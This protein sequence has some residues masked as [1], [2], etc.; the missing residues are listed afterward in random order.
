MRCVINIY[1]IVYKHNKKKIPG[2]WAHSF[3]HQAF[4]SPLMLCQLIMT[5][6][7]NSRKYLISSGVDVFIWD[8]IF[9]EDCPEV[10]SELLLC[11]QLLTLKRPLLSLI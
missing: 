8:R 10:T 3:Q 11:N 1:E 6:V 5:L 4:P 2:E 7:Y 9:T